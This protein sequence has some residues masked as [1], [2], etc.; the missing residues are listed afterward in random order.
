MPLGPDRHIDFAVFAQ[1]GQHVVK[2]AH[3]GIDFISPLAVEVQFDR[4]IRFICF[5]F[6]G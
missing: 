1:V 5:A 2:K 4:D 3:S 6:D